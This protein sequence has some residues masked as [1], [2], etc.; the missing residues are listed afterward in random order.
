MVPLFLLLDLFGINDNE[1]GGIDVKNRDPFLLI[2]IVVLFAPIVETLIMQVLP[3][4]ITQRIFGNSLIFLTV[5]ISTIIFSLAHIGYS[6]WYSILTL[7]MG[8]LLA[9]TYIIF[10]KREESGFWMVFSIHSLR[11]LLAVL[12]ILS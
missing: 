5:V 4:K 2:F 9:L 12:V 8:I 11:N 6:I 7:P 10:Q 1:V 3:I